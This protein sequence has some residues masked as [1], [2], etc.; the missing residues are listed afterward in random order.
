MISN[1][2]ELIVSLYLCL[3]GWSSF[4]H[5]ASD[6]ALIGSWDTTTS[7][8][9]TVTIEVDLAGWMLRDGGTLNYTL[10]PLAENLTFTDPAPDETYYR[11][12]QSYP[13]LPLGNGLPGVWER[14][15][16][17]GSDSWIEEYFYRNNGTYSYQ[18]WLNGL[19]HDELIGTYIDNSGSY[20]FKERRAKITTGPG[21]SITID[22]LYAGVQ[23]GVYSV[24]ASGDSWTFHGPGKDIVYT[25]SP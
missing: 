9:R 4:S 21:L 25:R 6:P 14:I 17:N 23:T 8:G 19:F 18:S 11:K 12:G 22:Q 24:D 15:S 5:S 7:S 16:T 2:R 10:D 20:D 3:I 13:P 1:R